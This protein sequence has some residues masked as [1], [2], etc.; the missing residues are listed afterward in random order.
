MVFI[1]KHLL[2][3]VHAHPC[4]KNILIKVGLELDLLQSDSE[5]KTYH[6]LV[7]IK[8]ASPPKKKKSCENMWKQPSNPK[9]QGHSMPST[10]WKPNTPPPPVCSYALK[11]FKDSKVFLHIQGIWKILE[12]LFL[13]S[14]LESRFC[15]WKMF[16]H[17]F[18]WIPSRE[19]T[20]PTLGIGKSSSKCHFLGDMLVPWRVI[21]FHP[22]K[23]TFIWINQLLTHPTPTPVH[24]SVSPKL[25]SRWFT[26]VFWGEKCVKA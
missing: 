9:H 26:E 4:N 12:M 18:W 25:S 7:R 10:D 13:S 8:E 14:F 16:S 2:T 22:P 20:Y 24:S 6:A 23:M 15:F 19:L 21:F 1:Q 17:G 5:K 11:S 3:C